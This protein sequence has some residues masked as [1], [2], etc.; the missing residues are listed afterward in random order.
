LRIASLHRLTLDNRTHSFAVAA[1]VMRQILVDHSRRAHAQKRGGETVL[2]SAEPAAASV[3]CD[4]V[5]ILALN[6]A[7]EE[8]AALEERLC[9]VVEL[10]FFAG[11][12]IDET[13]AV[14]NDSG[15]SSQSRCCRLRRLETRH[16]GGS[17]VRRGPSP[18]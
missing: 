7:L 10:K 2:I 6:E 3:A 8:L 16:A 13:A 14:L 9:R 5:D 4:V 11:L 18:G 1:R 17:S 15:A 12:T